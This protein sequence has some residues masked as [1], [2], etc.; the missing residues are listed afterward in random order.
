VRGG[1]ERAAAPRD[2]GTDETDLRSGGGPQDQALY[3]C[4]CGVDFTAPVATT[5]T[6]PS[7]GALQEW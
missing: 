3:E 5:V 6:C 1:T 2:A 7:C 4:C